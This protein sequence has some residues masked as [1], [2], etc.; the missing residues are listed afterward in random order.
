MPADVH[1]HY[2]FQSISFA[3]DTSAETWVALTS[4]KVSVAGIDGRFGLALTPL[5]DGEWSLR[6]IR[7]IGK[8]AELLHRREVL[9]ELVNR[10]AALLKTVNIWAE[11][12]AGG[13]CAQLFI[14][15]QLAPSQFSSR[16]M[17]SFRPDM[18]SL[19]MARWND[20][21]SL[22]EARLRG[23][24]Y[25]RVQGFSRDDVQ[26]AIQP[27]KQI[28]PGD[29]V[30][31]R[32]RQA[33]LDSA[34]LPMAA[35]LSQDTQGWFPAYHLARSA[36]GAICIDPG[37]NYLIEIGLSILEL[38]GFEGLPR[39]KNQL[40]RNP[41]TQHHLCLA[42]ELFR[43]GY[44]LELEPST[45]SG[46]ASN[47]LL[48]TCGDRKY[49]IEV[50]EFASGNPAKKLAQEMKDK[51]KSLPD[52]PE[53]PVV[54][55]VVLIEKG[56]FEKAKEDLFLKV[57]QGLASDLPHQISAVIVGRRFVDASGG[58]VKRDVEVQILN[59]A[60]LVPSNPEDLAALFAKNYEA[61][62]YPIF[63]IGSFFKFATEG[64]ESV[65]P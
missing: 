26:R 57:V 65:S 3:A 42:A 39:L 20:V 7:C 6:E 13:E 38:Q 56:K 41:G 46:G 63:G 48:V 27:L 49:E 23:D 33:C 24:P 32:Y 34:D 22:V 47:D 4:G 64:A 15:Q 58:R 2:E 31:A 37:W 18:L 10:A 30:R 62:N 8:F 1:L 14:N 44:L 29:W 50:K 5:D 53:R 54:F 12:A 55:H 51:C 59:P 40:A 61:I 21:W 36:L 16:V 43:R 35:D 52:R 28:F 11:A 19:P 9:L 25:F 45:G 17:I 60:A